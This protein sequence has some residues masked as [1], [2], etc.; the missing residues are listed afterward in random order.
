MKNNQSVDVMV[1][2]RKIK[3]FILKLPFA[4]LKKSFKI[5]KTTYC[6]ILKK[7]LTSIMNLFAEPINDSVIDQEDM[8]NEIDINIENVNTEAKEGSQTEKKMEVN[9]KS[10]EHLSKTNI[11]IEEYFRIKNEAQRVAQNVLDSFPSIEKELQLLLEQGKIDSTPKEYFDQ[12]V[13]S[14]YIE[15]NQLDLQQK[16]VFLS[17]YYFPNDQIFLE[18]YIRLS[19]KY[20]HEPYVE[21]KIVQHLVLQYG[22]NSDFVYHKIKELL[23][24]SSYLK[25]ETKLDSLLDEFIKIHMNRN[26]NNSDEN[27]RSR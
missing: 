25:K 14:D 15:K 4:L 22:Y 26:I 17:N 23:R 7:P 10:Q 8:G 12:Y 27:K 9:E 21:E 19:K 24:Y 16:K 3:I 11:S 5:C 1:Y 13:V 18:T 20:R 6:V 2:G